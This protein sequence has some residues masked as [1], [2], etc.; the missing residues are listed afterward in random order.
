MRGAPQVTKSPEERLRERRQ[1][2]LGLVGSTAVSQCRR[3]ARLRKRGLGV[4]EVAGKTGPRGHRAQPSWHHAGVR[5]PASPRS[6]PLAEPGTPHPALLAFSA[7]KPQRWSG[8]KK[9]HRQYT[10][11]VTQL[12]SPT[13]RRYYMQFMTRS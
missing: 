13:M 12:E 3:G 7:T 10:C 2:W 11:Q 8:F 1:D 4:R 9:L 5:T 6:G